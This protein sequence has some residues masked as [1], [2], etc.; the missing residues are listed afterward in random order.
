MEA[1]W[2]RQVL[3]ACDGWTAYLNNGLNGGDITAVAPAIA[4]RRRWRCVSAEHMPR[5]GPGHAA[6]QLWIQGPDGVPPLMYVRTLAAHA[7][8]GR[9]TWHT[10]GEVQPF[11]RADRYQ[12]RRTRDRLDRSLLV[13]YLGAM[14]IRVD[15]PTFFGDALAVLQKVDWPVRRE[16][17]H[18][19]RVEN[20][21]H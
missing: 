16:S 11:E 13:E 18:D 19:F 1:P 3:I 7:A 20:G 2:T 8:D 12:A 21:W 14:G 5:Y 17:V 15:D 4:H 10:S 9:W 6:T